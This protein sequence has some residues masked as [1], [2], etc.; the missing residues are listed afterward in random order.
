MAVAFR[1]FLI[2]II[3]AVIVPTE[4]VFDTTT[5]AKKT[6]ARAY[7]AKELHL[8]RRLSPRNRREAQGPEIEVPDQLHHD[9][10]MRGGTC[11]CV[12]SFGTTT[13]VN[14]T[15]DRSKSFW[16]NWFWIPSPSTSSSLFDSLV[17][18]KGVRFV[19]Y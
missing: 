6:F 5:D 19:R 18:K 3:I 10:V 12:F 2:I 9:D 14:T 8:S 11:V 1:V 13:G 15:V 4:G 16:R 7:L 17:Q